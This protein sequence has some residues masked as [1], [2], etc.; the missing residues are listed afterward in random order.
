MEGYVCFEKYQINQIEKVIGFPIKDLYFEL[1]EE[2]IILLQKIQNSDIWYTIKEMESISPNI[3]VEEFIHQLYELG[4]VYYSDKKEKVTDEYIYEIINQKYDILIKV[5]YFISVLI[6]LFNISYISLNYKDILIIDITK[7]KDPLYM[8]IIMFILSLFFGVLH[9]IGHSLAAKLRGIPST[10]KISQ[11]YIF[12]LVFECKMNEIWLVDNNKRIFPILGGV[13]MDNL[14]FF[15]ISLFRLVF[16]HP[17]LNLMLFILTIKN[18]YHFIIPFKTDFYYLVLFITKNIHNS[19]TLLSIANIIGSFFLIPLIII[20]F[21]QLKNLIF[22]MRYISN[23]ALL[24]TITIFI[25][26]L[27]VFISIYEKRKKT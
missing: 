24:N 6:F 27:P 25:L 7:Y 23:S 17:V 4:V 22:Y 1:D 10:I 3:D 2:I 20:Y 19:D 16:N 8:F 11:R 18:L 12:F 5:I 26:L 13:L 21:I 15:I 14:V 9:E